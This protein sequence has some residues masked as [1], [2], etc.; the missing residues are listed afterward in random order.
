MFRFD[1][2]KIYKKGKE[3]S[4]SLKITKKSKYSNYKYFRNFKKIF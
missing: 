2:K 3:R 4:C 1:V